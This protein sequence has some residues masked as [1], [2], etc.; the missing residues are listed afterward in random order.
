[1][2]DASNICLSCGFC[3]DGTLIGY[4][5][6]ESKELPVIR[7]LMDIEDANGNGFFLQPCKNYCDGCSIYLKRPKQCASF[8]CGLLKSVEQKKMDFDSAIEIINMVKQKKIALEKKLA[9]L[10]FPLKSE[11]FSFKMV[12]L[13]KLLQKMKTDSLI[14]Q[15]HLELMSDI[16]QLNILISQNFGVSLY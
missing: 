1:M 16:D 12:E 10:P 9:I 11:S 13:K 15:N 2:N 5:E 4:V 3:C 6:L 8:E 14:T 7:E